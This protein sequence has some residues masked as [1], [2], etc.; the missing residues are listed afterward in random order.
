MYQSLTSNTNWRTYIPNTLNTCKNLQDQTQWKKTHF[1]TSPTQNPET[2]TKKH[3]GKDNIS[4]LPKSEKNIKIASFTGALGRWLSEPK[5]DSSR[6]SCNWTK[7]PGF[8]RRFGG[9]SLQLVWSKNNPKPSRKKSRFE[10]FSLTSFWEDFSWSL[11]ECVVE[12]CDAENSLISKCCLSG[13]SVVPFRTM[14]TSS[15]FWP[16]WK[17]VSPGPV[18]A[19]PDVM[20]SANVSGFYSYSYHLYK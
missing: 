2:S 17:I 10:I 15:D 19:N 7:P 3:H 16:S 6:S 13:V 18:R 9:S 4:N 5:S 12:A 8:F 20:D 11:S 1:H 14:K